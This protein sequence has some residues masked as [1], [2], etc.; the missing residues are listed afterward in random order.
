MKGP[1]LMDGYMLY[2]QGFRPVGEW[3][4]TGDVVDVDQAG[5][6]T[7]QA[8]LKRF[9]KVA[10]EMINLQAVEDAATACFD[11]GIHVVVAVTDGRK[12]ERILLFST[13]KTADRKLIRDHLLNE[14]HSALYV[15]S[16]V[17]FVEK[18]PLL[19]SGKPDYISLQK[20]AE[21]H[22]ADKS[23]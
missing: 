10:G 9:A 1:N 14:G 23:G 4:A 12:G 7:I 20:I 16:E 8:R 17:I 2:D 11:K 19:G 3:F 18:M 21:Q 6:V 22:M 15:P 5:F 13:L